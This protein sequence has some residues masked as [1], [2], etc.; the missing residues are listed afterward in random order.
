MKDIGSLY[1][2]CTE[3]RLLALCL[4]AYAKSRFLIFVFFTVSI[5]IQIGY[6]TDKNPFRQFLT[7]FIGC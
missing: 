4:I 7:I 3:K 1:A 5:L 2:F 6:Y